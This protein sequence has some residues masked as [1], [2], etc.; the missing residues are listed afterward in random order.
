MEVARSADAGA[1]DRGR[2]AR[3][4]PG[5]DG[6]RPPGAALR[7][8]VKA[9]KC[10]ALAARQRAAGHP[11]FTARRPVRRSAW[12][13]PGSATT[14]SS[15]TRSSTRAAWRRWPRSATTP[16]SR[17][18]STARPRSP[19]PPS[20]ASVGASIDVDVGLPR[21][22]CDPAD[23]GRLADLARSKGLEVRGVMGYEGH[24]MALDDRER[25]RERGR[26]GDGEARAPPTPTSAAT[27]VSAGGTGTYDLHDDDRRHRGPGRQLRP[28]GHRLRQARAAVRAG[29][30]SS[31]APSSR[32]ARATPSPTSG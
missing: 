3:R 7:P 8:H 23:A 20:P 4:Q 26:R 14:S 11:A 32:S 12:P 31:S 9:H 6:G 19:P 17:S 10:T 28:D 22:G 1:G 15:P 18:P 16:A 2:R 30:C 25:Q 24:L 27:I 29:R 5:D 21:C 13:P